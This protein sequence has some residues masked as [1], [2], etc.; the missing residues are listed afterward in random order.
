MDRGYLDF[1]RL[2]HVDQAAA[3]FIIRSKANT[4][5]RRLYSQPVYKSCGL[6]C[7]QI[8]VPA[9]YYSAKNYPGKLR[10]TKFTIKT[11]NAILFS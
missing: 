5:M 8:V 7:D 11:R 6:R 10:R 4:R 9:G 1:E 2:Y 3:F